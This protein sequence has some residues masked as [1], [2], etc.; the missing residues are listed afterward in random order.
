MARESHALSLKK[1]SARDIAVSL[2][3]ATKSRLKRTLGA[4]KGELRKLFA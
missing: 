4:A 3:R 1:R 2:K